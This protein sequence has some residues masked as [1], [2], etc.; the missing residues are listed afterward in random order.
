MAM[1]S[2]FSINSTNTF[3]LI[4]QHWDTE[5]IKAGDEAHNADI[6]QVKMLAEHLQTA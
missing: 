1:G 4:S 6:L 5:W 2:F 3:I